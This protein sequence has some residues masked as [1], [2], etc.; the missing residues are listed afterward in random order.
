MYKVFSIFE[1]SKLQYV[2]FES[3]ELNNARNF[4]KNQLNNIEFKKFELLTKSKKG[5]SQYIRENYEL[6]VN[7][8]FFLHITPDDWEIFWIQGP[9]VNGFTEA[10]KTE[11]LTDINIKNYKIV[12]IDEDANNMKL[13][14]FYWNNWNDTFYTND[15]QQETPERLSNE[16]MNSVK[17]DLQY[18]KLII[19]RNNKD[20]HIVDFYIKQEILD[21]SKIVFSKL[22][23]WSNFELAIQYNGKKLITFNSHNLQDILNQWKIELSKNIFSKVEK[24][25]KEEFDSEIDRSELSKRIKSLKKVV[26]EKYG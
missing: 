7:P 10:I 22:I 2:K 5:F 24:A 14:S 16:I 9:S 15:Y 3:Q 4:L 23:D 18:V 19:E 21:K 12:N 6:F 11:Q 20:N 26:E 17:E 25:G 13:N 1:G 8:N